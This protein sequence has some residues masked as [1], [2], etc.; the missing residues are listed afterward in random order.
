MSAILVFN[1]KIQLATLW[2]ME[3]QHYGKITCNFKE[4]V[5]AKNTLVF[6]YFFG[7]FPRY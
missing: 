4:K 2:K 3:L 7:L 6:L 5:L 1:R